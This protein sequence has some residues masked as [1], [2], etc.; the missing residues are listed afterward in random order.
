MLFDKAIVRTPGKSVVDGIDDYADAGKPSY[1]KAVAE[2]H[3]YVELLKKLG[4]A[5]TVLEPL[6][7][8]PDSCFVEDPAVVFDDFAVVTNPARSTRQKEREFIRPVLDQFFEHDQ[9]FE[10]TAPGTLEGGDV[11][12]VDDDLIY[13]GLSARTNQAGIDQFAKIAACFGKTVKAVPVEQV[14][15]LKTGTT[16]LGDNKLLVAGEY[17]DSPYFKDF[18]QLKVPVGEDYAVNCINTGNGV[19]M[20]AGFPG[21]HQLLVENGF[22]VYETDMSEFA[23][24]DGGLTCLSLRFS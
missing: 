11:M 1:E 12:P 9:I 22:K 17:I 24:I 3:A 15:H 13:V 2:H 6:E 16:Y 14:L 21:V 18:D 4:I 8:F 10:I 20:P 7:Q 23:K 19:I 5:V